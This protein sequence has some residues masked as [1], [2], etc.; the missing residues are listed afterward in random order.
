M[1][2]ANDR[3]RLGSTARR[4]GDRRTGWSGMAAESKDN[5]REYEEHRIKDIKNKRGYEQHQ[6]KDIIGCHTPSSGR[7]HASMGT[8]FSLPRCAESMYSRQSNLNV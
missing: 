4:E 1:R 6:S 5:K 7:R 8:K 2:C 3:E